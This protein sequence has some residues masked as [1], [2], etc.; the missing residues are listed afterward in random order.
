MNR[1]LSLAVLLAVFEIG[2]C[3][4]C[5]Q[6]N[7]QSDRE[8]M[9]PFNEQ[10]NGRH[11]VDCNVDNS[12][13]RLYL[14]DILPQQLVESVAGA[15]KYC[16][17]LV[18]QTGAVI[19]TCLDANPLDPMQTCRALE[20]NAHD[21]G[22]VHQQLSHCSICVRDICNGSTAITSSITLLALAVSYLFFKQ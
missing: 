5:Y 2:T 12:Y 8:C 13:N 1:V 16:A 17:K 7:S 20:R 22:Q 21:F 11:L 15:P 9:D 14:R 4:R 19:R 10:Y 3:L 18:T 6:C